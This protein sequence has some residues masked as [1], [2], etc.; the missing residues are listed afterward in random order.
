[1][2][3]AAGRN[4]GNCRFRFKQLGTFHAILIKKTFKTRSGKLCGTIA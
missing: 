2:G 4:D 3:K 1:M